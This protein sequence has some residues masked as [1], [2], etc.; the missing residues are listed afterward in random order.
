MRPQILIAATG[1]DWVAGNDPASV[2]RGCELLLK[3]LD[4][5][6]AQPEEEKY[7]LLHY[8][9]AGSHYFDLAVRHL[10]PDTV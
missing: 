8:C 5:I 4:A 3:I 7:V 1:L 10:M 2:K 6:L 9:M